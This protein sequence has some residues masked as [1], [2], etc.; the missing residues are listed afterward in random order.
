VKIEIQIG[1]TGMVNRTVSLLIEPTELNNVVF[2]VAFPEARNRS[3]FYMRRHAKLPET[4][5]CFVG[6]NNPLRALGEPKKI[7]IREHLDRIGLSLPSP[8]RFETPS[9]ERFQTANTVIA[10]P[11]SDTVA[12][13][14]RPCFS[15]DGFGT[16]RLFFFEDEPVSKRN[17]SA[18]CF[19]QGADRGLQLSILDVIFDNMEDTVKSL[20]GK[21]LATEGLNW[22]VS[23]V[24][25]VKDGRPV[26]ACEIAQND[27]DLRHIFGSLAS[28]EILSAY[29]VWYE[30]WNDR[31]CELVSEKMG[32]KT[33]FA[34][35][36]HSVIGIDQSGAVRIYQKDCS[37]PELALELAANGI[38]TAGLL[39]SGGSCAVYDNWLGGYLNHGWYF[40]EPR[41]AILAF[42][43][44][45]LER[46]PEP[47]PGS[48]IQN[49]RG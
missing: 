17:Y 23:L 43:L 22:A 47:N 35:Y 4:A 33:P 26:S 16:R 9:S 15:R 19:F 18:L 31:V 34:V 20:E 2:N 12:N 42:Q 28:Q 11:A 3:G 30:G 46:I 24:P 14:L 8:S 37:L 6:P 25:L 38:V 5:G 32:D 13:L 21:D 41:G 39:D 1:C 7:P 36:Y 45:A 44:N 27:Y 10:I 49:R 40:R 48:W 29:D